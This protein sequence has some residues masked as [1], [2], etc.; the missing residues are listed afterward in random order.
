MR[1]LRAGIEE[2]NQ[3]SR[4]T[5]ILACSSDKC[6]CLRAVICLS[7]F[8][9]FMILLADDLPGRDEKF[10]AVKMK[11]TCLTEKSSCPRQLFL[12]PE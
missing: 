3:D 5:W 12:S 9:L 8:I 6:C 1:T 2:N 7:Y 4:N 11:I 10:L